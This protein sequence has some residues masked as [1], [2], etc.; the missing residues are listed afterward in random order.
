MDIDGDRAGVI[1]PLDSTSANLS[2][3]GGKGANLSE[4]ARAGFDVPPGFIVTTEA[5]RAFVEANEIQARLLALAKAAP[6]DDP[7]ALESASE[8]I[9]ALFSRGVL[10]EA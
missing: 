1:L 5:Y 7:V 9:G 2:R 10:P 6:A 3:A 8:A 4:L